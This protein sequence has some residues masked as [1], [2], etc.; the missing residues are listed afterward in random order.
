MWWYQVQAFIPN[1][2]VDEDF[3]HYLK[4]HQTI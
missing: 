2:R 1:P 3:E 4:K